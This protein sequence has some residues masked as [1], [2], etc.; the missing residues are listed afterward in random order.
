MRALRLAI[1][2]CAMAWPARGQGDAAWEPA[3]LPEAQRSPFWRAFTEP[4]YARADQLVRQGRAQ[5]HPALE[6]GPLLGPEVSRQRRVALENALARFER[7]VELAPNHREARLLYGKALASWEEP[8]SGERAPRTAEAIVQLEA[9]RALDP[10]YEAEEVAFQ[11]GILYTRQGAFGRARTEYERALALRTSDD[12]ADTE[13]G[14]LAEVTMMDGD[15]VTA[16]ALYQRAVAQGEGGGRLL[17]LWGTAVVLDRLGEHGE[18]LAWARRASREDRAPLQALHQGGVFFVP[19]YE[20]DYY[21]ALGYLALTDGEREENEGLPTLLAR[22]RAWLLKPERAGL[23]Q[24]LEPVLAELG[25]SE[26]RAL[27]APLRAALAR[28]P[29]VRRAE[30]NPRLREQPPEAREARAMLWALRALAAFRSYLNRGGQDGPFAEDA[31]DHLAEL[32]RALQP[33]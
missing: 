19:A 33:R 5:L 18:A 22:S 12:D 7:A 24:P 13:L 16:L 15:L 21:E 17:A 23:L 30:R 1:L 4:S 20:R 6:L 14:N 2:L 3:P 28:V 10:L 25:Q 32:A 26:Q 8:S 31:R 11:L 29:R 9:L 27:V